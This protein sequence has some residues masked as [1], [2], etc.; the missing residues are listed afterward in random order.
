[1]TTPTGYGHSRM[2][3]TKLWQPS[4]MMATFERIPGNLTNIARNTVGNLQAGWQ[5]SRISIGRN[6]NKFVLD[7]TEGSENALSVSAISVNSCSTFVSFPGS[8]DPIMSAVLQ[9]RV[10]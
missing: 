10:L 5:C 1:M 3:Q 2:L 4:T 6:T 9:M 7:Q 8:V